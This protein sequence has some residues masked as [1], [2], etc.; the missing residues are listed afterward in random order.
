M[1]N[2][3]KQNSQ[4]DELPVKDD[5]NFLGEFEV[6][7]LDELRDKQFIVAV[8]TGDPKLGQYLCST[9]YGPYDFYEM[10]EEVGFMWKEHQ[11]HA[12]VYI[13]N[14]QRDEANAFLDANTVDYIEAHWEDLVTEGLLDGAFDQ[15]KEY[16]CRAGIV[17]VQQDSDKKS[18]ENKDK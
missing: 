10:I 4:T 18:E 5:E 17:K 8:G 11:H 3:E 15:D 2:Q 13:A 7:K 1:E 12:R 16:T 9:I 14:K 6:M